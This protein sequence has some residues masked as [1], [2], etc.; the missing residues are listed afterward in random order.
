MA[1]QRKHILLP[2]RSSCSQ[3][4]REQL[5]AVGDL[6][7]EQKDRLVP[8]PKLL[9]DVVRV[10]DVLL[11][12]PNFVSQSRKRVAPTV[13][14]RARLAAGSAFYVFLQQAFHEVMAERGLGV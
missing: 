13:R 6:V 4:F 14:P 10:R 9:N 2:H 1:I 12:Q 3:L 5:A 11:Q 7:A 8:I